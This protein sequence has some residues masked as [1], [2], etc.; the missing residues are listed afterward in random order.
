MAS[1]G[2]PIKEKGNFQKLHH[3]VN[4]F[5]YFIIIKLFNLEFNYWFR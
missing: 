5:F 1:E 4:A 3:L 2:Q